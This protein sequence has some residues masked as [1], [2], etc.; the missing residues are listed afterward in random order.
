MFT[1]DNS[2]SS[3]SVNTTLRDL[4]TSSNLSVEDFEDLVYS[5]IDDL[6]EER[7]TAEETSEEAP[8]TL[9]PNELSWPQFFNTLIKPYLI[10]NYPSL[11]STLVSLSE[12][13][14]LYNSYITE[15]LNYFLEGLR[16]TEVAIKIKEAPLDKTTISSLLDLLLGNGDRD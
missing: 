13:K 1:F 10:V 6:Y 5:T 4:F 14:D 11:T 7:Q 9:D 8:E 15:G 2:P 3:S 16:A 12:N